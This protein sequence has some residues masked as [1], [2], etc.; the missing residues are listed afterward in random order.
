MLNA[1]YDDRNFL[2]E[3]DQLSIRI[4]AVQSRNVTEA[5][6]FCQVWFDGMPDPII[7]EVYEYRPLWFDDFK[8]KTF[9]VLPILITC[10]NPLQKLIPAS[11]SVVA[12]QCDV[13]SN[14]FKVIYNRPENGARKTVAVCAKLHDFKDD[15]SMMLIEWIE[16]LL[17]LGADKVV[18]NVVHVH[19]NMMKVISFYV[20]TGRVDLELM[21]LPTVDTGLLY[22][23]M[24]A[25][26]DCFYKNIYKYD[27]VTS[28]DIDEILLPSRFEDRTWQDILKRVIPKSLPENR[29][30]FNTYEAEMVLFNLDN[31]HQGEIQP[32]VPSNY[33]FLQH[34]FRSKYFAGIGIGS[35]S[36]M[37]TK[38]IIVIHNHRAM[39][40]VDWCN[41][42]FIEK[43]D[44]KVQHYRNGCGAGFPKEKCEVFKNITVRDATLWKYKKEL[45][46]N[47]QETIKITKI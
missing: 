7:S 28:L 19:P 21:S 4:L 23:E 47:V 33:L 27:F 3:R 41:I 36:F 46:R 1:Y 13:P 31:N 11:V 12:Q 37:G 29:D 10:V 42:Y 25:I 6:M 30:G 22:N 9:E 32:E 8:I 35:K 14:I 16:I 18:I 45:V 39:H 26:N 44:A 43:E 34:V 38:E 15:L 40:C 5:N 24:I 20:E 2:G 17:L